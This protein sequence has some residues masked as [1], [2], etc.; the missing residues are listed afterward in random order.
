MNNL[1]KASFSKVKV[2]HF[3]GI[4]GIGM[5]GLAEMFNRLGFKVQGSDI[6]ENPNTIQLE[7]HGIK[8]FIGHDESNINGADIIVVS[9]AIKTNNPEYSAAVSLGIPIFKRGKM[10]AELMRF[11]WGIAVAGTHGKTT[12][13]SLVSHIM[14][15]NR[16]D[17][18]A[19]IGGIVNAWGQNSRYGDSNWLVAESDESDGSFLEL[20]ATISVIT[21]IEAEHMDHYKNYDDLKDHFIRFVNNTPFYGFSVVCLDSPGV[22]DILPYV[23]QR[24]IITYGVSAQADYRATNIRYEPN[25]MYFDVE[26]DYKNKSKAIRDIYLPMYGLHNVL[27]ALAAIIVTENI[28]VPENGIIRS[29]SS[30]EGV[31]RRFT[32]IG[33]YQNVSFIDDYAHHPSEIAAVINAANKV[34]QNNG[35]VLSI[36]QPHR[37]SRLKDQF[38]GFCKCF[39][40]SHHVWILDVYKAGEQQIGDYDSHKL[41][42]GIKDY[43][44]KHV[45]Y[46]E[47]NLSLT[48][49][50]QDIITK[51][52]IDMVIFMGAGDITTIAKKTLDE[53]KLIGD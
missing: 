52:N 50:I 13:T 33:D 8:I 39:N 45:S 28:D 14:Q 22:Q 18:T 41:V 38:E 7:R 10:L 44:H 6:K 21:N 2:I 26:T 32:H 24:K 27:N 15:Y 5:S 35:K 19:I 17:P 37:Y 47:D 20:P 31:K 49:R 11:K 23:K 46:I 30:F 51:E 25:G 3:I 43:G 40:N 12:T 48:R 53:L 4:G 9:S 34:L 1:L 29:L 16:L 36:V 42:Q